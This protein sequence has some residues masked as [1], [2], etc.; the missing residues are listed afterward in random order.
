MARLSVAVATVCCAI[1]LWSPGTFAQDLGGLSPRSVEGGPVDV[2][3]LTARAEAVVHG[4]VTART[5][6][7]IG[8]VLYTMYT[9]APREILKGAPR[10]SLVVAV[11]GGTR[12]NVQLRVPGAPDLQVG[13]QLIVFAT[14]LEGSTFAPVGTIDGIVP[15]RE[16]NG[17]GAT[18]APRG[19]PESLDAFL[20]EVRRLAGR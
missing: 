15:I 13:E 7:W 9:V 14:P 16:G 8:R 17:R 20:E 4:Q 5:T 12:G 10:S 1:V 19:K 11:P 3:Q 6:G 2:A 18:V